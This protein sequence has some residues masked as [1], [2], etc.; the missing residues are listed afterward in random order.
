[1]NYNKINMIQLFIGPMYSSKTTTLLARLERYE[2]GGKKCLIIKY[3][4]DDRY[5][6]S[7][8]IVTHNQ[9]KHEAVSTLL[10]SSVNEM[11]NNYD[12]ILIDEI[13]FY[14]DAAFMCDLWASNNKIVECYGLS[15]DYKREPFEQISKLIPLSDKIT[16]LTAID[17]NNGEE[18]PF[19][20]R[21]TKDEGQE[22]IGGKDMYIALSRKSYID[23]MN[24]K[25]NSNKEY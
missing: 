21:I 6:K 14:Q 20:L 25:I 22:V 13:Q 2:I 12:V 18:A 17:K 4:K 11:I 19:T 5:D 7:S 16:H 8:V 15:G 9:S 24:Q 3:E 1:M 10:L 23:I